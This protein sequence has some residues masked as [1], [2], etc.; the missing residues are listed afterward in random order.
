MKVCSSHCHHSWCRCCVVA[1]A[2]DKENGVR[3]DKAFAHSVN[4]VLKLLQLF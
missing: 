3:N 2:A 1:G 4:V